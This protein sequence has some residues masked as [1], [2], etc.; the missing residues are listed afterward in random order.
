MHR[1]TVVN[2]ARLLN[3][4][5]AAQAMVVH[6]A[7]YLYR[8]QRGPHLPFHRLPTRNMST[9][10]TKDDR[11]LLAAKYLNRHLKEFENNGSHVH[12]EIEEQLKT[13]KGL[14][15]V[16]PDSENDEQSDA[17]GKHDSKTGGSFSAPTDTRFRL[18][19]RVCTK[20][21]I[22]QEQRVRQP[23]NGECFLRK[24]RI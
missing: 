12:R 4:P 3:E 11:I 14:L 21:C 2:A 23:W 24:V 22:S 18:T 10:R 19:P 9:V 7:S 1:D 5:I 20:G 15:P 8:I 16:T 6:W 13:L 17:A